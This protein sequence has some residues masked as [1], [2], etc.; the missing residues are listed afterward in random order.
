[1]TR[2]MCVVANTSTG[3]SVAM[4]LAILSLAVTVGL[5]IGAIPFRGIRL[6]ISG[7]LFSSLLFGQLGLTIDASAREFLSNF[8]LIVFMYAMG[9][10][11]G[12]GFGASLRAQGLRLNV[13]TC[14]VL[15]LGAVM[16]LAIAPLL[17]RAAGPGLYSGAF[18]STPG[19]AAA[20]E[21]LRGTSRRPGTEAAA[22]QAGLAYSIS[23][24]FGV[25]GPMLVIVALRRTF[26]VRLDA[27]RAA[28]ATEQEKQHPRIETLDIEVT[29][30]SA[31]VG[32]Q[33]RDHALL[34][35]RTIVFSRM[36]R[37]GV[38]AVPNGDT[39][40]QS[41]DVYRAVGPRDRL[42]QLA[43]SMG[44]AIVAADLDGPHGDLQKLELLVTRTH[45]LHRS[46]RE[47]D[48]GRR[49][50][51]VIA[52]VHRCGISFVPT[53]SFKLMFADRVIAVGPKAGLEA[54]QTELGNSPEAVD[55]PQL[56]PIF[57]GIV[58]G[59]LVGS[60]PLALPGLGGGGLRIGLAGGSLLAAIGLSR[61][62]S[63]GSIVWYM[64]GAANQLFRN[65]GLAVFLA[66]VGLQ[67]GD[68][69]A[70]R[71]ASGP[72]IALLVWGALI[73]MLPLFIV[74]C[75][76][77][78]A[79]KMNFISLSGWVAGAM[80]SSPALLF[81]QEMTSSD[82][83]SINYAAVA[84]LGELLPIIGAQVLAVAAL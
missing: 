35:D 57:L 45:V 56:I 10:E 36:L 60:V 5:A 66:C 22:A 37:D 38:L 40:V 74:A 52:Q 21:T 79:L 62:G 73:T 30:A 28:M 25:V 15:A 84:P 65:F 78:I 7:V 31:H 71:A 75:I 26:R 69:F 59:V 23:Y 68:H 4:D 2:A 53:G 51:V 55:R 47:L 17:P 29:A 32:R 13:L 27:E 20:Q 77:R 39:R 61:L 24:P 12:P 58:L 72:G 49:D 19:L 76:A 81:A 14:C 70:Q 1:M 54:L 80:S 42:S 48:L 9:L 50:G 82:A 6:G 33:L 11:V 46:L 64:P 8:A 63:V 44:H 3:G 83:P 67:A 18:T 34:S 41:G 43:S 16:T